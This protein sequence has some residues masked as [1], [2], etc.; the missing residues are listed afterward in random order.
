M[1]EGKK[2]IA[3]GATR[4]TLGDSFPLWKEA[5]QQFDIT[6]KSRN[7]K[8]ALSEPGFTYCLQPE[9]VV[10]HGGATQ[11]K[12]DNIPASTFM[13]HLLQVHNDNCE[14]CNLELAA[15]RTRRQ[16]AETPKS[17]ITSNF[18]SR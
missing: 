17:P 9:S 7:V 6:E 5:K 4:V 12:R 1:A 16:E 15:N 11:R 18:P 13:K 8:S 14:E 2:P 10:S 3:S